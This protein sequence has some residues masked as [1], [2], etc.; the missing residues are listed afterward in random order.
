MFKNLFKSEIVTPVP[1]VPDP[2]S[3]D[4]LRNISGLMNLNKVMEKLVCP[5]IVEDMK[6]SLDK[7]QISLHTALLDQADR[8]AGSSLLQT[9]AQKGNVL[10][11]WLHEGKS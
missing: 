3:M 7:S 8:Q 6:S 2:K 4:D 10:L 9:R 1:K 11:C 5:L